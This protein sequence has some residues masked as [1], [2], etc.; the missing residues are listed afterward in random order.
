MEEKDDFE[1]IDVENY[2]TSKEQEFSHQQLVM[3]VLRKCI[4]AGCKEMK[5]GY[6]NEKVDKYGN[7]TRS[8]VP[9]TRKEFIE[10]VKSAE[11][12]MIPDYDEEIIR[13]IGE[14]KERLKIKLHEFYQ[15][16]KKDWESCRIDVKR[17]RW[18]RGIYYI[19]GSL[20]KKLHYYHYYIDELVESYRSICAELNK[21]T[22]RLG[23]YEEVA[24]EN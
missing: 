19:E 1:V 4:E 18:R 12:T 20:N 17:D 8:Y 11:M 9:D 10:A 6:W 21:L 2:K 24:Y 15:E 14:I 13:K 22:K 16:E 3:S 5:E 7:P 23:Y